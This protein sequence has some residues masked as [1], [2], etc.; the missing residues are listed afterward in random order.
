MQRRSYSLVVHLQSVTHTL[1]VESYYFCV[2]Q[3]QEANTLRPQYGIDLADPAELIAQ[4][5]SRQDVARL[6]DAD[7]LIY[8]DLKDLED[9]IT[10]AATGEVKEF[11]VGVFNGQYQTPVPEGYFEHLFRSRN[12]QPKNRKASLAGNAGPLNVLSDG[13]SGGDKLNGRQQMEAHP[14]SRNDIRYV[15]K[16]GLH[17]AEKLIMTN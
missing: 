10:E 8:Q 9:A 1:F 4:G 13:E 14:E 11:E 15:L 7:D 6:I 17:L 12:K 16:H 5:K 2:L 3:V